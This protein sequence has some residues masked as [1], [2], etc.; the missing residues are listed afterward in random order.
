MLLA[1]P[2]TDE[3][4]DSSTKNEREPSV[5]SR[6]NREHQAQNSYARPIIDDDEDG[7]IKS[8]N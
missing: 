4:I 1:K 3:L 8:S 6:N 7:F 2:T 5:Y